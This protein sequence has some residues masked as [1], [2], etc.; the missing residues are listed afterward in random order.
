MERFSANHGRRIS[1]FHVPL[2]ILDSIRDIRQVGDT[3]DLLFAESKP[4]FDELA[5]TLHQVVMAV[6]VMG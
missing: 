5:E 2:A 6:F 1:R 3:K 4:F